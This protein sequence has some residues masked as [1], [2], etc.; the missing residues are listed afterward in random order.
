MSAVYPDLAGRH[1][2]ITGGANGIGAE[3]AAAF[4]A[5]QARVSILDRDAA[6]GAAV[7]SA[8]GGNARFFEL[9]LRDYA[10]VA[11]AVADADAAFG[12]IDVLVN[13]AAWDPRYEMTAMS[14]DEWDDLFRLNVGHYFAAAKAVI[15]GMIRQSRGSIIMVTSNQVWTAEEQLVCYTATKAAI[16]GMV[17]SLAREVG[18]HGVRV[19]AIAPGWIMTE[20]QVRERVTPE[21]KQRLLER[22]QILP[23]LLMPADVAPAF[24]FLASD[25]SRAI[26]RQTLVVDAG[27]AMS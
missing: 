22:E 23:T 4:R 26:T 13:N 1:V 11:R 27:K 12:T 15:P 21:A 7:A 18:R 6:A 24:L 8:L 2:L 3:V 9:D 25:A 10:A 14:F 19:N 20:R 16:V 17:R 5:Q